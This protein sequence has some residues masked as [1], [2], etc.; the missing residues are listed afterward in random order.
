VKSSR[1]KSYVN[2]ASDSRPA[3]AYGEGL[4]FQP[5]LLSTPYFSVCYHSL[6]SCYADA[7]LDLEKNVKKNYAEIYIV[8]GGAKNGYLNDLTERYTARRV[9]A[10]PIEATA[11]GNLTVQMRRLGELAS[12]EEIVPEENHGWE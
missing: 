2:E 1:N 6:A 3:V 5:S 10:L 4:I 12:A 7:I 9:V 8:G 11:I